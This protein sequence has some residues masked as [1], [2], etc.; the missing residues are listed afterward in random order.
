[1]VL[2]DPGQRRQ[3]VVLPDLPIQLVAAERKREWERREERKTHVPI[4]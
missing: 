1:M 3:L 2:Y 4:R